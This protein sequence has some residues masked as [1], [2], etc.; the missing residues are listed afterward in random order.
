MA[1]L[2][3]TEYVAL[4]RR[5]ILELLDRENAAA[6]REIEAKIADEKW[7]GLPTHIDP[8][9][10]TTARLELQRAG[11]IEE[12]A[13]TA[14]GGREV[15][16]VVPVGGRRQT[17]INKAVSR[18]SLLLAR[19]LGWASGTA[20]R[21]SVIGPAAEKVTHSSLLAAAP[22]GYRVLR[23]D[24]AEVAELLGVPLR[25][26]LDNAAMYLHVDEYGMPGAAVTIPVEVKNLR[27]WMMPSSPEV[28]Q[29]LEK[30]AAVQQARPDHS[31][32]P[33]LICRRVHYTLFRM[34][35]D[36]G[37]F[38]IEARRQFIGAH[39]DEELILEVRRELGFI[40]L[41][42]A[43]GADELIVR[44]LTSTLPTYAL[45]RCER[46]KDTATSDVASVFSAIRTATT[47]RQRTHNVDVLRS[48][49]IRAGFLEEGGGW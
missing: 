17:A 25:G 10:L 23:P 38:V 37:F 34:A 9:H 14:R 16:I 32:M 26:P 20:T 33:V 5:A 47:T 2:H 40:D 24:G 36:L 44:R 46:W 22:Y 49:A 43:D 45:E 3:P 42:Q 27:D 6:W 19:Y 48:Y 1:R 41:V 18:K 8:N 31:I 11:Q 7:P 15:S 29:L 28:Y 39:I 35:K 13:N 30:A 4:G 12:V 21:K